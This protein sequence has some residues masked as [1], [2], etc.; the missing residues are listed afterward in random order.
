MRGLLGFGLGNK[1][2]REGGARE[3]EIK[4]LVPFS[5]ASIT[6]EGRFV[7]KGMMLMTGSRVGGT[8][9]IVT[10]DSKSPTKENLKGSI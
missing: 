3:R 9:S 1:G 10:G 4:R 2:Q 8:P 7:E 6:E 5:F